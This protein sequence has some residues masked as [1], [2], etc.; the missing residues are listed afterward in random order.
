MDQRVKQLCGAN[1]DIDLASDPSD[2]QWEQTMCPWNKAENTREHKCAV[3]NISICK[4]FCGFKYLDS[5]LCSYPYENKDVLIKEDGR[6]VLYDESLKN[7]VFEFTEKCFLEL[8][9]IFEPEGR[10]SFYNRIE[11]EFDSFWCLL[12]ED[13]VIGTVAVKRIDD[14][15]AELK[16]LYLSSEFR[17]KGFGY[18]L[19][20]KAVGFSRTKGY[21]RV[22]LDSMSEY[23]DAFKLYKK[24]GFHSIERYNDNPYADVF[25]EYDISKLKNEG[26][27]E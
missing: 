19:L 24:Y 25:M 10:H 3:K 16:A 2:I 7:K 11:T 15:T 12:A 1:M 22:V 20:D 27:G 9:K 8:G 6:I 4:Y 14:D 5:V 18:E 26:I 17:G 13:K 21:L 23:T